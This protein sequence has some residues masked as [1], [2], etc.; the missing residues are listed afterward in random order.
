V[1]GSEDVSLWALGSPFV[2]LA[3]DGPACEPTSLNLV[4]K[5]GADFGERFG[6]VVG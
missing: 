5:S 1:G 6:E 3:Q 2:Y 4:F